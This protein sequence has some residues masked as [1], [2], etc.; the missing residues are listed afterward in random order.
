MFAAGQMI[1]PLIGG[2]TVDHISLQAGIASSAITM[3]LSAVFA[4]AYG[5]RQRQPTRDGMQ[6]GVKS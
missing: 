1:G 3:L 5:L 2:L 4:A 6:V